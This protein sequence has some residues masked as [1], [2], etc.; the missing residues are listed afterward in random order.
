MLAFGG[1][2]NLVSQGGNTLLHEATKECQPV[3]ASIVHKL[4]IPVDALDQDK[5]SPLHQCSDKSDP[6]ALIGMEFCVANGANVNLQDD[7]G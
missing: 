3:C 5:Q 6:D 1:D 4:G 7:S 2:V